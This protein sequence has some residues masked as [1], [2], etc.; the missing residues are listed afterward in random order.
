MRVV[1]QGLSGEVS[2]NKTTFNGVMI[3]HNFLSDDQVANVL[4]FIRNSF[5]N[6]GE[7][8]TSAEVQR[9]RA[10]LPPPPK[11]EFE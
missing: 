9:I 11:S 2:V 1:L 7:A 5:G 4:T 3:P 6:S 10:D 8:V